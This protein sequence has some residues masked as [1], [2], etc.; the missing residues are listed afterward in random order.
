MKIRTTLSACAAV[1]ALSCLLSGCNR[2]DA[3]STAGPGK[4]TLGV[5]LPNLTNPYYVAMKKSFEDSAAAQGMNVK[6]SIAD[7]DDAKQL[8]QVQNFIEQKVDAVAVNCV[9][10]GPCVS[11]ISQ[12]NQAKIPAFAVNILPDPAGLKQQGVVLVQGVQTDQREG[13]RLIGQQLLKDIGENSPATVGIVGEPTSIAANARDEG[14]KEAVASK[15]N[16]KFVALVNGMVEETTSLKV[17]TEMLQGRPEIDVVYSDT[18][19]SALGSLAAIQQLGVSNRVKLYAFVDKEGVKAVQDN[20]ILKAGAIQEPVKLAQLLVENARK[21]LSGEQVPAM[22][23]NPPL[24][25]TKD[26]AASVMGS[27]Y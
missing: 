16:I 3:E 11:I 26:N 14:F 5:T 24:L 27:A 21:S 18:E 17:T 12:L 19:P 6:I 2:D 13:G 8:S 4:K 25:V 20:S 9:S 1:V 10:S 15:K 7:N 22:I 23:N